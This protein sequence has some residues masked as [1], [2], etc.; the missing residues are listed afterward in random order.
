MKNFLFLMFIIVKLYKNEICEELKTCY[1]CSI[2]KNNCTWYNNKCSSSSSELQMND[3]TKNIDKEINYLLFQPLITSQY[4]CI[5]DKKDI[6]LFKNINNKTITLSITP[7]M[8]DNFE[9]LEKINYQIYCFQYSSISNIF[10]SIQYNNNLKNNI[11]HLSLYDNITN[12]DTIINL[13]IDKSNPKLKIKSLFF[14]IKIT[15]IINKKIEDII[16][17]QISKYN[18][19]NNNDIKKK[20]DNILSYAI[21]GGMILLI[22]IIIFIFILWHKNKSGLMKE[23]IIMNKGNIYQKQNNE[24]NGTHDEENNNN[25]N[26]NNSDNDKSNCS[27][28]QEKYFQLEHNSFVVHNYETLYSFVKNI[29]DIDKKDKYLKT[30]IKTMPSFLIGIN[31]SDLIGSFCSFCENKIKLNDNVCLLNCGHIFHYDC[32]YQQ[33]ITNEEYKC[34][35]CREN[36]II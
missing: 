17:F 8:V 27:E 34:I 2:S 9:F 26:D 21:L 25:G 19:I 35:I 1:N 36:I 20:N 22:S 29:H 12:T 24:T 33:I 18:D 28:L 31:N 16:S 10:L 6:A 4:K 13:D 23:I 15:Y 32:I 5:N 14:C 11:I 30:I 7:N 3:N